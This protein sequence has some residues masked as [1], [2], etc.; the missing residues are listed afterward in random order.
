MPMLWLKAIH[1]IM[2]VA[3]FAGLFYMFRLLV[4]Q[5]ENH[6]KPETL[7]VLVIMAERLYRIITFPAM[8]AT[9]IAAFSMLLLQPAL[10]SLLWLQLKLL[11]VAALVA[12]TLYVGQARRR[13]SQDDFF[14]TPKQC[15][16]RNEIPTVLLA[17]I[18]LLAVL[19]PLA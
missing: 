15:R 8:I 4:Y 11:L 14:L 12:Y 18:V 3:W 2:M 19:R 10:F 17:G 16:L 5:A 13:F 9:L 6:D 1:L 7:N